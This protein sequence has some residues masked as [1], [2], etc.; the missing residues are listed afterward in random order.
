MPS[1]L[2][3][4][5]LAA[6][7]RQRTRA[8][9]HP[10]PHQV[11]PT[12]TA[13]DV[14]MLLGGRGAGKTAAGAHYCL[15]T[16]RAEGRQ[17]RVYVGGKTVSDARDVCAEGPSGLIT[18][19]P[20]EFR[21]NR[22]LGEAHHVA[23]GYVKFLGSE[24]P[25]RWNGPGFS[26][27]WSDELSLWNRES[28]DMAM[29]GLR[30]GQWPR[31]VVTTTPKR[32]AFVRELAKAPGTVVVRAT[33]YDNLYRPE[34]RDDVVGRCPTEWWSVYHANPRRRLRTTR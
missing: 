29:F 6:L 31:A 14:W 27:L 8:I 7:E 23:G 24:E 20:E 26:L 18:L 34:F 10:E 2:R 22:S 4:D 30:E 13:W 11:P 19:A 28:W 21:Y 3:D 12:G 9:W 5:L 25:D 16:L 1:P 33:T 32:R 17:A 15:D